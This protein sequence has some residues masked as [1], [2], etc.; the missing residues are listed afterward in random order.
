MLCG[1]LF[2][3]ALP[4]AARRVARKWATFQKENIN[5]LEGMFKRSHEGVRAK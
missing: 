2:K 5:E 3:T 1:R 4:T